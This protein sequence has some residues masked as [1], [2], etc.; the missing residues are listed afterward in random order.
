VIAEVAGI[1]AGADQRITA[2]QAIARAVKR[3]SKPF[4]A[5]KLVESV[6]ARGPAAVPAPLAALIETCV[7]LARDAPGPMATWATDPR[8]RMS[9]R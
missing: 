3:R 5:L 1:Q 6:A 9:S 8:G 7:R 4:L 2:R